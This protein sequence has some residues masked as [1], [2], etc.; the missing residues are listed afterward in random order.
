[1]Q[2]EIQIFST[3][4]ISDSFIR[5]AAENNIC[6][7]SLN[8]IETEESV[9][10]EM[11]NHILELSRQNI[12]AIFTS[13]N[14]VKAVGKIVKGQ[15]NW[16]IFCIEPSTKK[17]VED[18]FINSFIVGTAKDA[19]ALSQKI[20]ADKCAKQVVFFCGNQRRDLLPQ[21]LKSNGIDVEELI[22]YKSIGKPQ[23]VSKHYDGILFFSPSAV[24]S[25]FEKNRLDATTQ[26]F[27]IGKTTTDEIKMFSNTSIIISESPSIENLIGQVIKYFSAIKTV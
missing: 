27:S 24:R 10:D 2:N 23:T 1:M 8:F 13:S 19:G 11:K 25:F 9:S 21:L 5:L 18:I 16:R 14:A 15:T 26:I 4:K 6:I 22:V 20:I 3:K 7:H 12:N 17:K